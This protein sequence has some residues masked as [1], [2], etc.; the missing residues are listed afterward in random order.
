MLGGALRLGDVEI[1]RSGVQSWVVDQTVARLYGSEVSWKLEAD[2][3]DEATFRPSLAK[4]FGAPLPLKRRG[5]RLANGIAAGGSF[6]GLGLLALGVGANDPRL[7]FAG[8]VVVGFALPS[9]YAYS[10]KI[11][12]QSPRGR[13]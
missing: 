6:A 10:R 5:S 11:V 4:L 1:A 7:G 9:W 13:G 2:V 3:A 8:L 12:R